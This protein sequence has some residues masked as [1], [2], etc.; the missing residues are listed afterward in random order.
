MDKRHQM[1]L[2]VNVS[3]FKGPVAQQ[4]GMWHVCV[5]ICVWVWVCA[6]IHLEVYISMICA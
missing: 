1:V 6:H 4:G 5:Y 2:K 3:E